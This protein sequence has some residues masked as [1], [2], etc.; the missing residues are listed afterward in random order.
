MRAANAANANVTNSLSPERIELAKRTFSLVTDVL[1]E[2]HGTE[3]PERFWKLI[4]EEHVRNCIN[5]HELLGN[6]LF[7]GMNEKFKGSLFNPG[8][9]ETLR[10]KLASLNRYLK[11]RKNIQRMNTAVRENDQLLAGFD[12]IPLIAEETGGQRIEDA[13]IFY[14]GSGNRKKRIQLEEI[15]ERLDTTFEKN[16]ILTLPQLLVEQFDKVHGGIPLHSPES[17]IFHVRGSFKLGYLQLLIAKYVLN[18][19]TLIWYQ[20]GA[21]VGECKFKYGGYLVRSVA[22]EHLTWGWKVN[23]VDYPWK[24][25]DLLKF[26]DQYRKAVKGNRD[27]L[28]ITYPKLRERKDFY[29]QFT[30]KLLESLDPRVYKSIRIRPYPSRKEK[31]A[32]TF[33]AI[34]DSRVTVSPFEETMAEEVANSRVVLHMDVPATSFLESLTVDHPSTGLLMNE[35]PTDIVKPYYDYFLQN[36]V[37]HNSVESL[38]AH[39][40]R[41][42]IGQWWGEVKNSELYVGYIKQFANVNSQFKET[43]Q[44]Q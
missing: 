34:S 23:G 21:M 5:H 35:Y 31:K 37:L 25:Y 42:E 36:G 38:T 18:E 2:L 4:S 17:K 10:E 11:T 22:D 12:G 7:S 26:S 19:A 14:F 29:L 1:N 6:S 33:Q 20:N 9:R 43:D 16:I 30:R 40:N 13:E 15:T 39:L 32:A 27:D 28:L 8:F 24:A 44:F 41:A 3:Y